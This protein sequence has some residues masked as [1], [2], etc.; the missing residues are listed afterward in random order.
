MNF[1]GRVDLGLLRSNKTLTISAVLLKFRQYVLLFSLIQGFNLADKP[2]SFYLVLF[3][4]ARLLVVHNF[5]L[6]N[7]NRKKRTSVLKFSFYVEITNLKSALNRCDR[8]MQHCCMLLF[9]VAHI[10]M[11]TKITKCKKLHAS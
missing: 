4:S 8:S 10:S 11:Y 9:I 3:F 6:N 1:Y 7:F 5:V 2:L